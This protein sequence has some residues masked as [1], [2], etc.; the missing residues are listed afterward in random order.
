MKNGQNRISK[1][2][3]RPPLIMNK[4]AAVVDSRAERPIENI[5]GRKVI[6]EHPRRLKTHECETIEDT[7]SISSGSTEAVEK[8]ASNF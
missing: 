6:V 3:E 1:D 7:K 2:N 5:S 8:V 4:P